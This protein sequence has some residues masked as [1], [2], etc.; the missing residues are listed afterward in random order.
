MHE[1]EEP[2]P[3]PGDSHV[4]SRTNEQ[5]CELEKEV[6]RL[7]KK[8]ARAQREVTQWKRTAGTSESMSNLS[9]RV[10]FRTQEK[11]ENSVRELEEANRKAARTVEARGRFVA[12]MSHEIRTPM[13]GVIGAV[14][15]L[16][17][18][19]LDSEQ[20][21]LLEILRGSSE[22]L[23]AIVN[24][25]L[26]FSRLESGEV[27]LDPI[28]FSPRETLRHALDLVR[29]KAATKN[30][31]LR[32]DVQ[33]AV[34]QRLVGDEAKIRQVLF[35]LVANAV[36]FTPSGHVELGLTSEDGG[37]RFSV[38]D[39]GIGI[40]KEAQ[41]DIFDEFTQED[42][43]TTR[44]FGGTGLGLA[45][46][47]R[48]VRALGGEIELTSKP[49][50]G[51]R[52]TFCIPLHAEPE[53]TAAC[54]RRTPLAR[55]DHEGTDAAKLALVVDDHPVNRFVA[56]KLM[57]S[58]GFRVLEAKNGQEAVELTERNHPDII[59]MDCSMPVMDGY[60]TTRRIR[61]RQ[62]KDP[63]RIIAL[64]AS[65]FEE[66]RIRCLEAGMDAYLSKPVQREQLAEAV[67]RVN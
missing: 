56:K 42:S 59:L 65:A 64:T 50:E 6:R 17:L 66:D 44:R 11:L 26:D 51:S 1:T 46:S 23:L 19:E 38:S 15:L 49:G 30:L 24:R 25:V 36:R 33:S 58:L 57:H 13:N 10:M 40:K 14:E 16:Q 35:N 52:F 20:Q 12:T 27:E 54:E 45:I 67:D 55:H 61:E 60:E 28:T 29:A 5:L 34:P 7:Q 32:I 8:L 48:L 3:G 53:S 21:Q 47:R 22:A 37:Y 62:G 9:K 4:N 39:T 63:I 18:T 31:A 41:V 2:N 43:T